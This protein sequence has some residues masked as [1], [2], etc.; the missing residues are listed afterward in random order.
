MSL[1]HHTGQNAEKLKNV[2]KTFLKGLLKIKVYP[3][4]QKSDFGYRDP[5]LLQ[6]LWQ[7]GKPQEYPGS[8]NFIQNLLAFDFFVRYI[9]ELIFDS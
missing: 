5:S 9:W 8:K 6:Y 3:K 2:H 1:R 4:Y 7:S